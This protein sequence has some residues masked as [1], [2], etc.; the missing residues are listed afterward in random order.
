[1]SEPEILI[2]PICDAANRVPRVRLADAPRC[3]KC[4]AALFEGKPLALDARRFDR[5]IRTGSLPVLV[6][7]WAEWCGP[8]KA[9]APTFAA[10]AG[11]LEPGFRLVKI[12]TEAEQTLAHRYAIRSIPTLMLVVGGREVARQSGVMDRASLV[13]WARVA[14]AG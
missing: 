14:A 9:M 4:K 7:F 11:D 1:M 8:C 13:R 5:L 3:G 12:D 6:D 2:C 10:A